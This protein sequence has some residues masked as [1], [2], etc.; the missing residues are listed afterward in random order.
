MNDKKEKKKSIGVELTLGSGLLL[1]FFPC[2]LVAVI[3][4]SREIIISVSGGRFPLYQEFLGWP[5]LSIIG[6]L[7]LIILFTAFKFSTRFALLTRR[8]VGIIRERHRIRLQTRVLEN[9][10]STESDGIVIEQK[11]SE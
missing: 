1:I 10:A 11:A 7:L 6:L 9:S 5:I 8:L 2:I 3:G 4:A